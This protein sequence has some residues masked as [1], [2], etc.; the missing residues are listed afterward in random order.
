MENGLDQELY[1]NKSGQK[2]KEGRALMI[3]YVCS[4]Q[5]L[6]RRYV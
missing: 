4:L 1:V 3:W 6:E 5:R 2:R